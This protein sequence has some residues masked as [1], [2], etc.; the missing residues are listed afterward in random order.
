MIIHSAEE[1]GQGPEDPVKLQ[2][3][4]EGLPYMPDPPLCLDFSKLRPWQLNK[5]K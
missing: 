2:R 3:P 1:W 5:F 4:Q